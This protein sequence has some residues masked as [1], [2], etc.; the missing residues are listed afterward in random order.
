MKIYGI[1][2]LIIIVCIVSVSLYVSNLGSIIETKASFD[3]FMQLSAIIVTIAV[4][5]MGYKSSQRMIKNINSAL[6]LT[7]KLLP[8]RKAMYFKF[9]SILFAAFMVSLFFLLTGNTNLMLILA[10]IL[11]FYLVSKPNPLRTADDLNLGTEDKHSLMG[12]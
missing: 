10:I 5:P 1:I 3:F 11:L 6:S 12:K 9:S 2:F 8:Y 4:I 7:E